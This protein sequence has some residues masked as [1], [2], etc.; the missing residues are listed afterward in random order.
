MEMLAERF[1]NI[2]TIEDPVEKNLARVNQTQ[3]NP[4]AGLTFETGL[5]SILRQD[6][7]II[8]IGETRDSETA[9]ISVRS[10]LT[11]H[12]V[13]S[14][15][16][17]NDSVSAIV[18]L[19]DMGIEEYL[20]ANSLVGIVA[21]RLVKKICPFCYDE[22]T[23]SDAELRLINTFAPKLAR[24]KG[25][26]NCNNTGFKG[27]IAVHEILTID[28]VIRS[29]ISKRATTEEITAYVTENNKMKSLQQ[30]LS[31]LVLDK[32]TSIGELMKLTYFVQ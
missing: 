29:M 14:S 7:D 18:R 2:S 1:V 24:G 12:L 19:L 22:Y 20:L 23:P 21:Q 15:L 8:L 6:P 28:G 4:P 30:S 32:T 9:V 13:L 16:H 11:G 5:R 25:C 26:H 27:R 31:K 10:A 17:T 3:I